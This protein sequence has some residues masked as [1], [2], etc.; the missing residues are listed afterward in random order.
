MTRGAD[1]LET[2]LFK[3]GLCMFHGLQHGKFGEPNT[4]NEIQNYR[5]RGVVDEA[6]KQLNELQQRSP[7]MVSFKV[8]RVRGSL[9]NK[10]IWHDMASR[11][12]RLCHQ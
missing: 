4:Q 1:M 10:G 8:S 5:I 12:L 2:C 9:L 6:N 11:T 3:G 7:I